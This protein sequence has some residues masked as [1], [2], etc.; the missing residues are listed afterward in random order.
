MPPHNPPDRD[1][2]SGAPP[3]PVPPPPAPHSSLRDAGVIV[4][5]LA[6]LIALS[7]G[8]F[9]YVSKDAPPAMPVMKKVGMAYFPQGRASAEGFKKGLADL[10][11]DVQ[12]FEM[13]LVPSPTMFEEMKTAFR[14]YIEQEG[15][16]MLFADH[17]Q[18]AR[19]AVEL[20]RDMGVDV[21]IVFLSR[22]HDPVEYG[23]VASY[24]SSGNNATGVIQNLQ[25][26]SSRILQFFREIEPSVVKVAVFGKGFMIPGVGEAYLEELK[27]QADRLGFEIVEFTTSAPPPQVKSE[28]ARIVATV[29]SGDIDA[30]VH[31]PGH[32]YTAQHEDEYALAKRLG[33]PHHTSYEDMPGGGHFAFSSNFRSSGE[34]AARIADKIFKGMKPADIP[35]EYG[36][37]NLLLLNEPRAK[38][39]GIEFSQN[40]RYLVDEMDEEATLRDL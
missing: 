34:Q 37:R 33:I 8:V 10:G 15:V 2:L 16:D 11:Y 20:T 40:M 31:I 22:F 30:I 3:A 14:R 21:P 12:Y 35:I 36:T 9:W 38:E 1:P 6:A 23:I 4:G 5:T 7:L 17:E 18:Q 28:F 19:A 32:F 29:K 13:E 39:T 25:D 27:R 26:V 24:Q